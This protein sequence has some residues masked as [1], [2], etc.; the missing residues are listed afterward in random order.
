VPW[1]A[2]AGGSVSYVL[3]SPL[4]G[5]DGTVPFWARRSATSGPARS[6]NRL[7]TSTVTGLPAAQNSVPL[8]SVPRPGPRVPTAPSIEPLRAPAAHS[9]VPL[10]VAIVLL[11]VAIAVVVAVVLMIAL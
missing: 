6:S 2:G 11:F 5:A 8:Q 4:R 3:D 1:S 9:P 10:A 7:P